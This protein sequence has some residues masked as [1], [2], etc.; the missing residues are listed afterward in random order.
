M[1]LY[2]L[3][4]AEASYDAPSD[5]ARPLTPHGIERT[6]TAAR[7]LRKLNIAPQYIFSSPRV[8]AEQTAEIIAKELGVDVEISEEVNFGFSI[9]SVVALLGQVGDDVDEVMFVGHNP[10]M[11]EVVSELTGAE[12]S[13]RKGGLARVDVS[14]ARSLDGELV[15]LI[16]PK[17]FDVLV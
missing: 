9:E 6:Q 11:S 1:K 4:H 10:S 12:L 15:W 14:S 3:R 8:R 7:V 2:F 5:E 17:I 16:A 13:L